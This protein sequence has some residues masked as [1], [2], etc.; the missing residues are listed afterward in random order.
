MTPARGEPALFVVL[1]GIRQKRSRAP[2]QDPA[3]G[4]RQRA[5]VETSAPAQRRSCKQKRRQLARRVAHRSHRALARAP[6]SPSWRC[7]SSMRRRRGRARKDDYIDALLVGLAG[8]RDRG[9][10]VT[11]PVPLWPPSVSL[12]PPLSDHGCGW[13]RT[14]ASER[15]TSCQ[16]DAPAR[17]SASTRSDRA[18]AT[19]ARRMS[20]RLPSNS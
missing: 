16:V 8:Q 5:V 12:R 7:K 15:S 18:A 14:S 4:D 1:A 2:R 10:G 19:V 3:M 11:R 6:T 20:S 9:L 17:S 13:H